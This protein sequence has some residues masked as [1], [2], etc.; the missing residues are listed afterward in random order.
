MRLVFFCLCLAAGTAHADDPLGAAI[1]AG[2]LRLVDAKAAK[3]LGP[4][5]DPFKLAKKTAW[6]FDVHKSEAG[7]TGLIGD[8]PLTPCCVET[9][10]FAAPVAAERGWRWTAAC[11]GE[12]DLVI[13]PNRDRSFSARCGEETPR[14][15]VLV[16]P[17]RHAQWAQAVSLRLLAAAKITPPPPTC[18]VYTVD[19]D[20]K[21]LVA[22][23]PVGEQ[24]L[25]VTRDGAKTVAAIEPAACVS[26][27][28]PGISLR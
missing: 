11:E 16:A 5:Y 23:C 9:Q 6:T 1:A 4:A 14:R 26:H 25:R 2:R 28:V 7:W 19:C 24:Y 10:T 27:S 20:P 17:D 3:L 15:V 13:A 12:E 21:R 8:Q 18:D 22:V